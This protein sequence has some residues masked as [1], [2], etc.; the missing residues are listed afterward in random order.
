MSNYQS[1]NHRYV[2]NGDCEK[3]LWKI[4]NKEETKLFDSDSLTFVFWQFKTM[5][6]A[7]VYLILMDHGCI[8]SK[9]VNVR[10]T[11]ASVVGKSGQCYISSSCIF[12]RT[13]PFYT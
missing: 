9:Y 12:W 10:N 2:I 11:S 4:T 6:T 7:I 3:Y 5:Y 1:D 13:S 8:F